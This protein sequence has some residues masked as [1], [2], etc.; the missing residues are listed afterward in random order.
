MRAKDKPIL[1]VEM[2]FKENPK[3]KEV[4]KNDKNK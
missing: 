2:V 4:K 1:K 3:V